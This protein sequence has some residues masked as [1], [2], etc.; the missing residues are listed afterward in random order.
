MRIE[1]IVITG[2]VFRTTAG[3]PNQLYNV[4]W[5]HSEL[6]PLLHE[7][8]GLPTELSYRRNGPD[9][10]L[11]I[12]T[13]WYQLLGHT[14]SLEAWAATLAETA[15]PD[16]LIDAM[17]PDY[18]GALVFGFE[19]S[20]LMRS[21]LDAIGAP[22]VDF[23]VSPIRFL[24]D[25]ALVLRFSWGLVPAHPGLLSLP[26]VEEAVAGLR[27]RHTEDAS[28][29]GLDGSCI[30]L[31]QTRH[32]KTLIKDGRFFRDSEAVERVAAALN[33]RHLVLKPHPLAPDNPLLATLQQQFEASTTEANIYSILASAAD[34]HFLT[35]S[36]SAG[37]EA[38]HFGHGVET[39]H[40]A[41]HAGLSPVASLWAHR[42]ATF[43]RSALRSHLPLRPGVDFEER[44]TPDRM[45][46]HLGSW[47]WRSTVSTS[48]P[49]ADI[50]AGSIA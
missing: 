30:F 5:L 17:R 27:A 19:L 9:D 49:P 21:V 11:A 18:A 41:A 20:P 32:D 38:R 35:I 31:G 40:P 6:S 28:A 15:P 29:P 3:D 26:H 10:G 47:G 22:W 13:E 45:R 8:T 25:L 4:R 16:S 33:G 46:R 39:F 50:A 37:I 48:P 14:P 7:L 36:S 43:W 1:R 42:S 34:V 23:E 44:V 24:E 2:D 12:I